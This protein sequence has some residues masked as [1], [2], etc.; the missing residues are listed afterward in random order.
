MWKSEIFLKKIYRAAEGL[1]ILAAAADQVESGDNESLIEEGPRHSLEIMKE[2][3]CVYLKC[4]YD[5]KMIDTND[6][7]ELGG[8]L[9]QEFTDSLTN[10]DIDP[11]NL[12]E[13]YGIYTY[14]PLSYVE[15]EESSSESE[16][17]AIGG[18]P[19]TPPRR[20]SYKIVETPAKR[21]LVFLTEQV[22]SPVSGNVH[23]AH[24]LISPTYDEVYILVYYSFSINDNQR[25]PDTIVKLS[26]ATG[27][28]Q[29]VLLDVENHDAVHHN[30]VKYE[31]LLDLI[32]ECDD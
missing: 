26:Q 22:G 23:V 8:T 9:E 29:A 2:N 4:Y 18:G 1:D 6:T 7:L 24:V 19:S 30:N 12:Q 32:G 3:I 31:D 20:T 21:F 11:N 10:D 15:T 14:N 16:G 28:E 13:S 27:I 25:N 5:D 17:D